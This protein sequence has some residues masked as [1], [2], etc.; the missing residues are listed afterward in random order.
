MTVQL[1]NWEDFEPGATHKV[2]AFRVERAQARLFR[3]AYA[4]AEVDEP[5]PP[6]MLL[7]G[8]L[9]RRLVDAYL[10]TANGLGAAGV[11]N[12][13]W[14]RN[15]A[16]G[17]DFNVELTVEETRPLRSKPGVGFVRLRQTVQDPFGDTIIT[18]R[19]NQF[20]R[21]CDAGQ[22]PKPNLDSK[23]TLDVLEIPTGHRLLG[24]HTFHREDVVAFATEYD[25]Q[26]FHLNEEDAKESLFG[27]L[28]ASGWQ[29]C[30][31]WHRL[32][33][34]ALAQSHD[35]LAFGGDTKPLQ[36]PSRAIVGF[37]QVTWSRP[38]FVGD[39]FHF[40]AEPHDTNAA[41]VTGFALNQSGERAFEVVADL[42]VTDAG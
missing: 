25:P 40:L 36:D 41:T 3:Q 19:S 5:P 21:M 35:V 8:A 42:S 28:C 23:P 6:G 20:M 27:G 30:S 4:R 12:V 1:K 38:A 26:R 14:H 10:G 39:T 24:T 29:T 17:V 22:I 37:Q 11:E 16:F 18:W 9:M 33:T 2:G 13:A 7:I 15:A 34:D 31:I 32:F